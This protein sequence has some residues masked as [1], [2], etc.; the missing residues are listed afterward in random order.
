MY[1][2]KFISSTNSYFCLLN[3]DITKAVISF[4][5]PL[6]LPQEEMPASVWSRP[7]V[8]IH[9][10]WNRPNI[11]LS[12]SLFYPMRQSCP[13]SSCPCLCIGLRSKFVR[14][15]GAQALLKNVLSLFTRFACTVRFFVRQETTRMFHVLK[16]IILCIVLSSILNTQYR[17][18][19]FRIQ[20]FWWI[21]IKFQIPKIPG[22]D[23]WCWPEI[24]NY[25][26]KIKQFF[27]SIKLQYMSSYDF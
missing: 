20:T 14:G 12:P 18:N 5:P 24:E 16:F 11:S 3:Y 2:G 26:W 25:R 4:F 23:F 17:G 15:H 13:P 10:A 7:L 27:F 8:L 1:G 9:P 19:W 6:F 22:S 21:Q